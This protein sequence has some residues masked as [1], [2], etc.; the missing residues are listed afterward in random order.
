M[1]KWRE[2]Y[3]FLRLHI[4]S[5]KSNQRILFFINNHTIKVFE[6]DDVIFKRINC[7]HIWFSISFVAETILCGCIC[8]P[9]Y[10][11]K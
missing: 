7:D 10:Q 3:D 6:V 8:R 1:W 11:Y 2:A 9:P 5:I 4:H